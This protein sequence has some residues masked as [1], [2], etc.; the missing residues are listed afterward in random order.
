MKRKDKDDLRL[1]VKDG[2]IHVN[3]DLTIRMFDR[4]RGGKADP[5]F[6]LC[7][8]AHWLNKNRHSTPQLARA[9]ERLAEDH[10]CKSKVFCDKNTMGMYCT[11]LAG[12]K[13]LNA[14]DHSTEVFSNLLLKMMLHFDADFAANFKA[15]AGINNNKSG[16][17]VQMAG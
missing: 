4:T 6:P 2:E 8:I 16:K 7:D 12:L 17:V 1:I 9:I 14:T 10:R 15:A 13:L 3:A 5:L 11:N